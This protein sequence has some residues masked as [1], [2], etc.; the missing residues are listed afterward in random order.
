MEYRFQRGPGDVLAS[1][2]E[3]WGK[4]GAPEAR[5]TANSS[6]RLGKFWGHVWSFWHHF[7]ILFANLFCSMVSGLFFHDFG[8]IFDIIVT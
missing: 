6:L 2:G 3:P 5:K 8:I 4:P 7:W 1:C